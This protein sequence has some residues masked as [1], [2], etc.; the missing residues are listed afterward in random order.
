MSPPRTQRTASLT[1]GTAAAQ[2]RPLRLVVLEGLDRGREVVVE[3]GT[4]TVG[5]DQGCDLV[6]SD[7]TVS[8]RHL[9]IE[10]DQQHG[11]RLRVFIGD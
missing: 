10:L 4:A 11:E 3:A 9:S 8:K 7:P 6:L 2:A 5:S 1:R